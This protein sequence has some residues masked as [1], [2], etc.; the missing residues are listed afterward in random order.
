L[1]ADDVWKENHLEVIVELIDKYPSCG[2]FAT[3]YYFQKEKMEP[4]T[5]ILPNRFSF[6]GENGIMTNY[7]EM[8]SGTDFPI[9]MSSYAVR[10]SV[11]NEMGGFP[12]GIPSG[13]DI[14]TLARLFAICDFAYSKL[15]TSVYYILYE[16]KND[17][18]IQMMR[19]LDKMFDKLLADAAHRKDVRRFVSS[20]YK[21]RMVGA[22]YAHHYGLMLHEFFKS[23]RIF[24]FQK[25]LYTSMLATFFSIW[26]GKDLYSINQ[27]LKNRKK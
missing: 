12:V 6:T 18:P 13:E 2:V 26:T 7:Y 11:M 9:H 16:T 8:A 19:P 3:S 17:R 1:D 15:P 10:R 4:S 23:L 24:P 22:I 14:I 20:W 21:R 27:Q 5:P 25:K